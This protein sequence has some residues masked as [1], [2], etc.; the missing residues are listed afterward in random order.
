MFAIDPENNEDCRVMEY[1]LNTITDL[2]QNYTKHPIFFIAVTERTD[3]KPNILRIFLEKFHIPKLNVHQRHQVLEWFAEVMQLNI[4][5]EVEQI[6][7]R[8]ELSENTKEVLQ[9]VAAKTETFLYGDLDTLVHFAM[10]ESYLKQ[11]NSYNRLQTDPN[12]QLVKEEDFNSALG[13]C[14]YIFFYSD[15]K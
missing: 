12:L 11:H 14:D 6:K 3:L 4:D 7:C 1:F 10:R 8:D 5:E 9:R 13:I 15:L 2:Y